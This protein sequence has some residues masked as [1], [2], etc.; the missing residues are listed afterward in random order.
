[1]TTAEAVPA[2]LVVQMMVAEKYG[3]RL[4]VDAL[5]RLLGLKPRTIYNQHSA[6][7]FPIPLYRDGG[8]LFADF[9]AVA[10]HLDGLAKSAQAA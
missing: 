6:G 3:I 8:R 4:D 1:M 7:T 2:S 9:R 10:A 5:S